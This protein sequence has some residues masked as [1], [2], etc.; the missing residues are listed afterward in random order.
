M[1]NNPSVLVPFYLHLFGGV[2]FST[3]GTEQEMRIWGIFSSSLSVAEA[4]LPPLVNFWT[5]PGPR[6]LGVLCWFFSKMN[7]EWKAGMP[8]N[9]QL[10]NCLLTMHEVLKFPSQH[11]A[12]E[13]TLSA[14]LLSINSD[15]LHSFVPFPA[16]APGMRTFKVGLK[17]WF[18]RRWLGFNWHK[19][20]L[21]LSRSCF[22]YCT[23]LW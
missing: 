14:V 13:T 11:C 22:I 17:K 5:F 18:C 6:L 20:P 15:S 1:R 19:L 23:L 21:T 8:G 4:H 16:Q 9:V 10:T 12:A 7:S 3:T 2:F